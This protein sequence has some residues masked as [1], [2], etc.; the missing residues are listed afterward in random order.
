MVTGGPAAF[1][2]YLVPELENHTTSVDKIA[3]AEVKP[4]HLDAD[5]VHRLR[6]SPILTINQGNSDLDTDQPTGSNTDRNRGRYLAGNTGS[7]AG[8]QQE[9]LQRPC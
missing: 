5:H 4:S 3:G 7:P 8:G 6:Y 9:S 2:D 1:D